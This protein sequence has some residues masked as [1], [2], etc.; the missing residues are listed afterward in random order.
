MSIHRTL[1]HCGQLISENSDI[2]LAT[3]LE[4]IKVISRNF[5]GEND[6]AI[7]KMFFIIFGIMSHFFILVKEM[8]KKLI[9]MIVF[10]Q[11]MERQI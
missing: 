11:N 7:L 5:F 6:L 2:K 10:R 9:F 1:N 8:N 3:T 4:P